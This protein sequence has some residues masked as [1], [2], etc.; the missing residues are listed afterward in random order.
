M[1][2]LKVVLDFTQPKPGNASWSLAVR[3][4]HQG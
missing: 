4:G 3:A 1:A 2:A